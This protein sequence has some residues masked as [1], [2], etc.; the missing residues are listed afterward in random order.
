MFPVSPASP[1]S[2]VFTSIP[3]EP[4]RYIVI[5]LAI[6]GLI[7]LLLPF[8]FKTIEKNLELFFLAMGLAA[9]TVSGLWNPD[10]VKE[11]LKSPLVIGALPVGIFQVV[12]IFG[13]L[14]Y[15]FNKPFYGFVESLAGKLGF[16]MFVFLL[17]LSLGL[18][19]GIISVIVASSILAE[20]AAALPVERSVKVR[21]VIVSCFSMAMGAVLTPI[22]EPLST[23]LV[24]KL[25]GPPYY[26]GFSFLP[27]VFGLYIIPG[28]IAV[29]LFGAYF[30][31][32]K[33]TLTADGRHNEYSRPLKFV[34]FSAF[35]VYAFVAALTF[36]GEGLSPIVIW[37]LSKISAYALYWL[38]ML[39]A[40][41]DNATL[42]AIEID[43]ALTLFQIKSIIIGLTIAGGMLIPGNI[44]NIVASARLGI[45]MKEWA[46]TGVPIGL[47]VLV[48]YF[49]VLLITR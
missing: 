49:I 14:V 22:G 39:S 36:L 33:V 18:L 8:L 4:V 35:R 40:V 41:L 34:F 42:T 24:S 11:A 25:A 38:N 10:L 1:F 29:S 28:I 3:P 27:K 19:S 37:Y 21:L 45:T 26:A 23:I 30:C 5:G 47:V 31:G 32:R 17:V 15:Y 13:L 7:V 20:V 46:K 2:G 16:K 6:I 43:P 48:I 44:P 9:V 12:L